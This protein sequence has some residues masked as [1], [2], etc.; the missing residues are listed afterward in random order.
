M[1]WTLEVTERRKVY[2]TYTVEADTRTEAMEKA[3][4]GETESESDSWKAGCGEV[5]DRLPNPATLKRK[6]A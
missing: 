1:K 5:T 2:C 3:E 4:S 6:E